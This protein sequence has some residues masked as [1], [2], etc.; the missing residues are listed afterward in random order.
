VVCLGFR[1]FRYTIKPM[2]DLKRIGMFTLGARASRIAR[3]GPLFDDITVN[4]N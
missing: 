2:T 1:I 4:L 3:H